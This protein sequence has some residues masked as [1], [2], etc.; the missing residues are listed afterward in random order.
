MEITQF[1]NLIILPML[2][3]SVLITFVRFIIGPRM[4]DRVISLDLI[5][6]IGIGIIASYSIVSNKPTFLDVAMIF[7]LIAFLGT[8]ALSYYLEKRKKND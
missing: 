2:S 8:V 1:I 3:L 6:T 5:I 7:A 4:P